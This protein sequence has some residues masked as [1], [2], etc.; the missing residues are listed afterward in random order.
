MTV[1]SDMD[2]LAAYATSL[3]AWGLLLL[4]LAGALA[5]WACAKLVEGGHP[6]ASGWQALALLL[7]AWLM[8]RGDFIAKPINP[9]DAFNA[10]TYELAQLQLNGAFTMAKALG[11]GA[12]TIKQREY[13]AALAQLGRA[14]DD[15]PFARRAE[16]G[17]RH[18]V[19]IFLLESWSAAYVDGFQ[20]R[21]PAAAST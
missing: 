18:N 4:A 13:A 17:P 21:H 8:I 9:I 7:L 19:V 12:P 5:A 6:R 15:H 14:P 16:G 1:G 20:Q 2:F 3:A 10:E 11:R